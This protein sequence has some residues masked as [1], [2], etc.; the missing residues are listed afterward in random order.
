MHLVNQDI[1]WRYTRL[2]EELEVAR[3]SSVE[4]PERNEDYLVIIKF[5]LTIPHCSLTTLSGLCLRLEICF[6]EE[7]HSTEENLNKQINDKEQVTAT[8][9]TPNLQEIMKPYIFEPNS[10]YRS[11]LNLVV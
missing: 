5:M 6:S 3:K 2:I 11:H 10:C 1:Q 9:E 7:T 4:V 8:V